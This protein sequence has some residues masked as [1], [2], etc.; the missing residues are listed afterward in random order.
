MNGLF[1]AASIPNEELQQEAILAMIE[2]VEVGYDSTGEYI[3]AVG[4]L[5]AALI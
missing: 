4:K 3:Q 5:T 1:K 2:T